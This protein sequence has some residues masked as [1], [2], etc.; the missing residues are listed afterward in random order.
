[1]PRPGFDRGTTL[2]EPLREKAQLISQRTELTGLS[3]AYPPMLYCQS[4]WD[5]N[6]KYGS[7]FGEG[8]ASRITGTTP[9]VAQVANSANGEIIA[10]LDTTSEVEFAGVDFTDEL[11]IPASRGV[12]M[13]VIAKTH[14]AAY[15][16]AQNVFIGL[17]TAY[18]SALTGSITKLMAFRLNASNALR[19]EGKDGTN[20]YTV[21]G[22]TSPTSVLTLSASTYYHFVIDAKDIT[23]VRFYANTLTAGPNLV[24]TLNLGAFAA[25]DLLQ[26]LIGV[27]KT[28][29]ATQPTLTLDMV[30]TR[31]QR[32]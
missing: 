10:T 18:N 14:S 20:S 32:F 16:T 24:G 2:T 29:G 31:W 17:A 22:S 28:T 11:N 5:F 9:T 8:L 7:G 19:V 25:T 21:S 23:N 1:M 3:S 27:Q 13:S 12:Y 15:T 26:P 4:I 6:G 30:R